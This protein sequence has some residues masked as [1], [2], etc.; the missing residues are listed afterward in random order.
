MIR[1]RL[2]KLIAWII[3]YGNNVKFGKFKTNGFPYVSVAQG[4]SCIIGDDFQ[5]NNGN[6]GNPIGRPQRCIFFVDRGA[7][8]IIG[9]RVGMSSTAIIAHQRI[10]IGD[11]VKIGGGVCIYDTDFHSLDAE[12]RKQPETDTKL[13]KNMPVKVGN[14][15]FIGA[16][17]TILKGVEI[18]E[19]SIIGACSVVSKSVPANEIWAGNPA[20]CIKKL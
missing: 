15:A 13:K 7:K 6:V 9:K 2:D 12:S 10:E 18:G 11:Y 4:G 20:I 3:F 17:S 8:L 1:N 5:M 19:N 14:N 16:H